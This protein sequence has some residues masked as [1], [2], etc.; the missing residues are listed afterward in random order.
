MKIL[1]IH[2]KGGVGKTTVA[3][4]LADVLDAQIIDLD[5]Q[6]SITNASAITGRHMPVDFNQ[7][8]A[9]HLIIDTPPYRMKESKGLLKMA[10]II[11]IP[12]KVS[13]LDLQAAASIV[14]DI[15]SLKFQKKGRFV[16]NEAPATKGKMWRECKSFFQSN[17]PDIA[18][19]QEQ[20]RN[21]NAFRFVASEPLSNPALAQ[22]QRLAREILDI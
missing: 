11:L 14:E 18:L 20:F 7:V 8:T 19:C 1:I 17:Y 15:R 6:K 12:V 5:P 21:Y 22:A 2:S 3:L 10:D 16:I 13:V 4:A 9:K